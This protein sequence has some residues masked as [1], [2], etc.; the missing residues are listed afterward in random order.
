[1]V[2]LKSSIGGMTLNRVLRFK[3]VFQKPVQTSIF[4]ADQTLPWIGGPPGTTQR[5][6]S[7]ST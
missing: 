3:P 1:M 2:S 7:P 4:A 5:A 6:P